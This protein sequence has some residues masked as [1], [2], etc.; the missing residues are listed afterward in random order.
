M[1]SFPTHK[2]EVN[3]CLWHIRL[4]SVWVHWHSVLLAQQVGMKSPPCKKKDLLMH[5]IRHVLNLA[6]ANCL[7]CT[8][9]SRNS[10]PSL[11]LPPKSLVKTMH[12]NRGTE[13]MWINQ[14]IFVIQMFLPRRLNPFQPMF[15]F[16]YLLKTLENLWG[17]NAI[18]TWNQLNTI[19]QSW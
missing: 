5:N 15:H 10:L 17:I 9:I 14:I 16:S 1:E 11:F 18:L 8:V 3:T 19:Q 6:W 7:I 4:L 13:S 2:L 12:Q